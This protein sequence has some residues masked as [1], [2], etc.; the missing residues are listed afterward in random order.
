MITILNTE[1]E[2]EPKPKKTRKRVVKD[3]DNG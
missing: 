3:E 2:T 1:K